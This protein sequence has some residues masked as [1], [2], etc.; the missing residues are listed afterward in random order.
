MHVCVE[1]SYAVFLH[2]E[3]HAR[4]VLTL[5]Q[6]P[7]SSKGFQGLMLVVSQPKMGPYEKGYYG[8]GS[9][10]SEPLSLTLVTLTS[11]L[12]RRFCSWTLVGNTSQGLL[13]PYDS[14]LYGGIWGWF[15]TQ[16]LHG[17]AIGLPPQ[18]DPSGTTPTDRPI[19]QSHG[20]S[21]TASHVVQTQ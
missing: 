8:C 5:V 18:T 2:V 20:L 10:H 4:F 17:T 3:A 12:G 14:Q 13:V 6:S 19:Y 7:D 21:G 1:P 15:I 11:Q 9:W 16:T